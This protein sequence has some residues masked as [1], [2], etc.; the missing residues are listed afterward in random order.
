MV[1]FW[2]GE[3]V[4]WRLT[5]CLD[6]RT[7]VMEQ[8]EPGQLLLHMEEKPDAEEVRRSSA[9]AAA[10]LR[11]LESSSALLDAAPVVEVLGGEGLAALIQGAELALYRQETWKEK[12]EDKPF[13][14]YLTG[15]EGADAGKVL[16][17]TAALD[18]W[19][20]FA[21][22]LTNR[23]AN[24]LT[25]VMLAQA[26]AQ[27]AEGLPVE[28]RVLDESETRALGMKAFH[29]V[30]D[31][32]DNPPRLIVLRWR[33]GREED[34]PIALVG[35]GVCFDS[36]GYSLKTSMRGMKGDMA[37]GAA[38][39]AAL[40]ALAE[41]RVPVNV[42]AVIPA[43]ENRISPASFLPD[44][45]IG[46]MSGKTIEI[47]STDAEGRLILADAITYAIEK[48][49]ACK[50]VDI[51]TLTGAI[52]RMLGGVA[53]GVMAN[54]DAFYAALQA[55]AEHTGEKFWRMP[56]YPE[57]KKLIESPVADLYN[58]SDGCGA[59]AAGLFLGAFAGET[60]WLHLDIAGTGH[61][62]KMSQPYQPKGAT[63]MGVATLYR[64][65]RDMA[66]EKR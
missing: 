43:V 49:N 1:K 65:C 30:G 4:Q 29:A 23:P 22:D 11:T 24:K 7:G 3:S 36:G 52:A 47:G 35:K 12:Q 62:G 5:P 33:G 19:I 16:E 44:D 26:V 13:T 28:V 38:V 27:A 9:R 31:S 20:C 45:V 39:S 42:T 37:G 14:L 63:G 57:Y 2:N 46:S 8:G 48:E 34:A 32:S 58:S 6:G 56:D 60:P 21:R 41:N 25:P 40:L 66:E 55:A 15:T 18:R 64:L 61:A 10:Q 51:A 54:D 59:I 50:V 53:A 17:E